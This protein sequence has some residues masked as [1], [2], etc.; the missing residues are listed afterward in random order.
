MPSDAHIGLDLW[1]WVVVLEL[2]VLI[3]EVEERLHVGIQPHM[4]Q[5][6]GL[7]SQLKSGLVEVVQVEMGVASGMDEVASLIACDLGHHH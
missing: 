7:T 3:L 6:S 5:R 4:G 1:P 2:E